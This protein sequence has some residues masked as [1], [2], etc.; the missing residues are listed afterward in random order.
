M[1]DLNELRAAHMARALELAPEFQAR[2]SWD[3]ATLAAHRRS[4]LLELVA[5]AVERSPWHRKR[6]HNADLDTLD[7]DDLRAL[8]VMT[9]AELM[10]DFDDIV[11]DDRLRLA[12]VEARLARGDDGYLFDEYTAMATGGSTGQRGV[13]VFDRD[14]LA[15]WWLSFFRRLLIDRETDPA[16]AGGPVTMAWVAAAHPS[17]AS[18]V[19]SRT[20]NDPRFQNPRFPLTLPW[21]QIIA[22]LNETGPNVLFS[23]P[24]GLALLAREA[25]AGR[26]HIRPVQIWC[27]GEPLLPEIRAAVESVF[28]VTVQNNWGATETGVLSQQCRLG[29]AHLSQDVDIVEPVDASRRP[30]APGAL[31]SRILITNLF[32]RALPLIRYEISD[33]VLVLPDPCP[34]GAPT[35]RIADVQGRFEDWFHYG[36]IAVH[37]QV[38][39]SALGRPEI[40]E[41]QVRQTTRGADIEVCGARVIE[42][43][44]LAAALSTQLIRLGLT[45]A[46]VKVRQVDRVTRVSDTGKIKR[47]VPL[48]GEEE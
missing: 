40:V 31:S 2:L 42:V 32:N 4:A 7:P 1:S 16:L 23:Y 15:Y 3:A 24:S 41:Y 18:A 20:F 6:M 12:D 9:K 19:I 47:F 45:S 35:P 5:T 27:A 29:A 30:V 39:R 36:D 10:A 48:A 8:P 13:F 26:L 25:A 17:H 34:C 33:E 46:E 22:G 21:T 44:A 28:G 43:A 37:P 11:T 14:G 38:F